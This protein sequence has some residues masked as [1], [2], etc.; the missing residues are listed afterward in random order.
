MSRACL[1]RKVCPKGRIFDALWEKRGKKMTL[2]D[3]LS[4]LFVM[5]DGVVYLNEEKTK[6]GNMDALE[7]LVYEGTNIL[8]MSLV[9]ALQ[10]T[11]FMSEYTLDDLPDS[12]ARRPYYELVGKP[13]THEQAIQFMAENDYSNEVSGLS[14][15]CWSCYDCDSHYPNGYGI[16]HPDG[17]VG[18]NGILGKWPDPMDYLVEMFWFTLKYPFLEFVFRVSFW[19]ESY[20]ENEELSSFAYPPEEVDDSMLFGYVVEGGS[21]KLL[22]AKKINK[23]FH[24]WKKIYHTGE[25]EKLCDINY[26]VK[27]MEQNK[28]L[29]LLREEI[30]VK[31]GML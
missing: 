13:I 3:F 9:D 10:N 23:R 29:A 15:A 22:S 14:L 18:L 20:P 24:Q 11:G 4:P 5:E 2:F 25:Q 16:V 31:G 28:L 21:I 30:H 26:C 6:F 19:N 12:T 7:K 17:M 1:C 27:Y 8:D